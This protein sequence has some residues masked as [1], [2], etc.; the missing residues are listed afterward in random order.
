MKPYA[1]DEVR[2][3]VDERDVR[4][5][6]GCT[7]GSHDAGIAAADDDELR[8]HSFFPLLN[9]TLDESSACFEGL[10]TLVGCRLR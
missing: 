5:A 10:V 8:Y 2:A 3:A 6:P 9:A 4:T 7:I 1:F